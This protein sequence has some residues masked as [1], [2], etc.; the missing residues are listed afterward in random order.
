LKV[1]YLITDRTKNEADR[2]EGELVQFG[3][4]EFGDWGK[5]VGYLRVKGKLN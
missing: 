1:D 4:G 2:F 5:V 3:F